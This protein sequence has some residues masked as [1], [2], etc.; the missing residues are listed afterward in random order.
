MHHKTSSDSGKMNNNM[1]FRPIEVQLAMNW[2]AGYNLMS[3]NVGL[4]DFDSY[5]YSEQLPFLYS[6][7]H[8]DIFFIHT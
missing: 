7:F 6:R 3:A 1:Q 4:P 2:V 5:L 8:H